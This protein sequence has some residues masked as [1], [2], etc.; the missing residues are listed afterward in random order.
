[1]SL[2]SVESRVDN[3]VVRV[4]ISQTN[5]PTL[6]DAEVNIDEVSYFLSQFNGK[7][8]RPLTIRLQGA[9]ESWVRDVAAA[10]FVDFDKIYQKSGLNLGTYV[11][12]KNRVEINVDSLVLVYLIEAYEGDK[13]ILKDQELSEMSEACLKHELRH[14]THTISELYYGKLRE[15]PILRTRA[16]AALG[17]T[18]TSAVIALTYRTFS[19]EIL[20]LEIISLVGQAVSSTLLITYDA[21]LTS[22]YFEEYRNRSTE[23]EARIAAESTYQGLVRLTAK[24]DLAGKM[25]FDY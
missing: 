4:E 11:P 13:G 25:D 6:A 19:T 7:N 23:V 15:S 24:V 20:G 14:S 8:K 16:I 9:E 12:R 18:L 1:M 10:E 5:P 3:R 2:G 17:F 22:H 21:Y